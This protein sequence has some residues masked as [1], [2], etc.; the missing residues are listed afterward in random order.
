MAVGELLWLPSASTPSLWV[1]RPG[2]IKLF[3]PA[4]PVAPEQDKRRVGERSPPAFPG[5]TM[6]NW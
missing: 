6:E 2:F 3:A 4:V 5:A 1:F